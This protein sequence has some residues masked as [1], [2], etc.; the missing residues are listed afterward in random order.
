MRVA[1]VCPGPSS[2]RFATAALY[3]LAICVNRAATRFRA[4]VWA[5]GDTPMVEQYGQAVIGTPALLTSSVTASTL[6]NSGKSWPGET[7]EH[8]SLVSECP[9]TLQWDLFS[10]TIALVYA[11]ARGATRIECY[12]MDW[13]GTADFDG[14][15]AG[16]N[17]TPERWE[18]ERA[19]VCNR[20]MPWLAQRGI[21][22]ERVGH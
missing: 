4:D 16:G 8:E 14:V 1:L 20:L 12:G 3:E 19:I 9:L 18:L 7:I 22:F 2:D 21:E 13:T 10:S 17:R 11:A 6:L 5:A 15:Q